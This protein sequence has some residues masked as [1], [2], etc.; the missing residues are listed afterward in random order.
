MLA[1]SHRDTRVSP[2]SLPPPLMLQKQSRRKAADLRLR[3]PWLQTLSPG[4]PGGRVGSLGATTQ[5][6]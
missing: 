6:C 4:F 1:R 3:S 5:E 2:Q